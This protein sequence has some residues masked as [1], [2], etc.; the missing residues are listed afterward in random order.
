MDGFKIPDFILEIISRLEA[1]GFEAFLVGGCLRDK[2]LKRTQSDWDIATSAE[3]AD[4]M[5]AF[6]KTVPT[7][8][9][10]GTVTVICGS[11]KAEVTT[12]RR[13]AKYLDFRRS[14]SVSFCGDIKSD[15]S[16]R[17]F[18]INAMAYNPQSGLYDPFDGQSDLKLGLIRAVG[19][20]GE[21]FR[22]DALRILRAFRF[23]AQLDF[24]I[25]RKT[26][27]AAVQNSG[28]VEK[29]SAERIKIELDKIL[30]SDNPDRAAGLVSSGALK[31]LGFE[32]PADAGLIL[33]TPKVPAVRW[34]AFL[35]LFAKGAD[36]SEILS[37]L[38]FDNRTKNYTL[39]L[40]NELQIA[41]PDNKAS[42]KRRLASGVSPQMYEEYLK[43]C[44][45]LKDVDTECTLKK[46]RDVVRSNEP[47]SIK[48]LDISGGEIADNVCKGPDCGRILES[49]LEKVIENPGFNHK[50]ILLS[51]AKET[52][53]NGQF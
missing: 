42:V 29:V 11:G 3:P 2:M 51:I 43:L 35:Y 41:P 47:Y 4:V 28:L 10:F 39:W 27:E 6:E 50:N 21:R 52:Y 40:L 15:L 16:R 30:L 45:T 26:L 18:T 20:P 33:K 7:G 37:R 23:A 14:S 1:A 46:L 13:E 17:D 24:Q 53:K 48:M 22:E 32:N 8:L 5:G 34:A 25:E 44:G 19:Q 31:F 36:F 9:K 38:K 12:F 49:L